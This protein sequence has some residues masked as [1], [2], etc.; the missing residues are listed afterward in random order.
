M[1][2]DL[3]KSNSLD[4]SIQPLPF[5]LLPSCAQLWLCLLQ[6]LPIPQYPCYHV[7]EDFVNS[8]PVTHPLSA[9][10]GRPAVQCMHMGSYT[11]TYTLQEPFPS[12]GG[13]P[14]LYQQ[15]LLP[16][17]LMCICPPSLGPGDA[18]S[19]DCC[20]GS[21]PGKKAHSTGVYDQGDGTAGLHEAFRTPP[22]MKPLHPQSQ[23][24]E[25]PGAGQKSPL[26]HEKNLG[27]VYCS[28]T[29]NSHNSLE[30]RKDQ[31]P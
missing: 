26:L 3:L 29:C 25:G 10:V 20:G 31:I 14:G 11:Q 18:S 9:S 7:P 13:H 19:R 15:H 23:A 12:P 16:K 5:R 6:V 2:S 17:D 22:R 28:L 21:Q 1:A 24:G 8:M 4:P 27:I 30:D